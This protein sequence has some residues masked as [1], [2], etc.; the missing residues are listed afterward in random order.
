LS[1]ADTLTIPDCQISADQQAVVPAQEAGVLQKIRVREGQQVRAGDLLAQIDDAIP[2]AQYN[3]ATFKRQVA[4]R[5]AKDEIDVKYA[6]AAYDVATATLTRSL[7][8]NEKTKGS[9]SDEVVDQQRLE[10]VKFFLSIEKAQ[11]DLDVAQLQLNVSMAEEKA[12]EENKNRRKVVAPL[13]AVV[14]ELSPHEGEWVQA[15]DPVMKL[16]RV[17]LLRVQGFLSAKEY[18]QADIRDRQVQV[19]VTFPGG[20]RVPFPGKVVYVKPV[21]EESGDFL[22][23]A[24]VQNRKLDGVWL[25]SPG[26]YGDMI[27]QMK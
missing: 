9:V 25:L 21:I 15:G 17:D 22:V 23:R 27:I 3:V 14:I 10:K 18:R 4:E 26:M 2:R 6:K 11:K 20:Q 5:Q 12:A 24:E 19:V 16:V 7:K 13:D 8:A 1:A